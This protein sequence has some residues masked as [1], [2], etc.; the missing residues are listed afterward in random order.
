MH[1]PFEN[2]VA[3]LPDVFFR[4][5]QPAAVPNAELLAFNSALATDLGIR[6][7][8]DSVELANVFSGNVLPAGAD[9]VALA[10][11]GHQFGNFVPSLGDGRAVLLGQVKRGQGQFDIQLKGSGRTLFS[12][13]GDGKAWLG[14]VLREYVVSEAMHAL[15]IPT[16]RALAATRTGET[17]IRQEGPV[18]GAVFTRVAQSH[19][20]VGTFQYFAARG[21]T[22]ALRTLF[23]TVVVQLYPDVSSP[24]ELLRAIS[25]RQ[26][27]LIAKWIGV[28][29]IHGVMNTDN[30]AVSG[31]TID[32]GP[33]AFMDR[34]HPATVY[35]SIDRMGRY[36]YQNQ[37]QIIAWN[38]AQLG[39]CLL[40][41]ESDQDTSLPAYQSA[42]DALPQASANAR[43]HVFAAKL[44]ISETQDADLGLIDEILNI[45]QLHE[46]D[47][48]N[49]FRA[50]ATGSNTNPLLESEAFRDW[51]TRWKTRIEY[52]VS[53]E[54]VMRSANP[55]FI[56][57]NHK[58]EQMI[59][60]AVAGD[61]EPFERLMRVLSRPYDDQPDEHDLILPPKPEEEVEAT[62]CGT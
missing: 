39:S 25:E 62:F 1:I 61:L 38:L 57:R 48:T 11:A 2:T 29:F 43:N 27:E 8:T 21:D 28:G 13:G 42:I 51:E 45:M 33:C 36:A 52:E 15:G 35:S 24:L 14:P 9:P 4:R 32:Y 60:A 49:T 3:N 17:I 54:M 5:A 7:A 41:L 12:R 56:P 31:E 50:L 34:Y 53:P 55:A 47:F 40:L 22:Q 16:T 23:E 58:I 20:R 26:V 30:T 6:A 59:Q 46:A 44:G 19:T 10:Y 37:P 18:P